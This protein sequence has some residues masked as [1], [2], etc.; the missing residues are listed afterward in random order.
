V[1]NAI[2]SED[3]IKKIKEL[4]SGFVKKSV[5]KDAKRINFIVKT[6]VD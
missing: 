1:K 5:T 3:I 4:I 2:N 6:F